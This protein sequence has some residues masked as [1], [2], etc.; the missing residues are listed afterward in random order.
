MLRV[1]DEKRSVNFY[2]KA[3]NLK[4]SNRLDFSDFSLIY[5]S[6][7]ENDFEVELTINKKRKKPYDLGDGYGHFAVCVDDIDAEHARL[8]KDGLNPKEVVH[9]KNEGKRIASFFFIND[10]DGYEIEVLQQDDHYK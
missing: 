10:P 1:L 7:N 4:V 9:F 8:I 6:N 5:L 3:F 2:D